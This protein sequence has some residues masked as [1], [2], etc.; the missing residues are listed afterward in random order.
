MVV[1]WV[2]GFEGGERVV[3]VEVEEL[4]V[5]V[6]E[7]R[8]LPWVVRGIFFCGPLPAVPSPLQ[9]KVGFHL[10]RGVWFIYLF[11]FFGDVFG[12]VAAGLGDVAVAD[13]TGAGVAGVC[14]AGV[15]GFGVIGGSDVGVAFAAT[16]AA[17][18]V[19]AFF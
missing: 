4:V 11:F 18:A 14:V 5:F 9:I 10:F 15:A 12:V 1:V 6:V 13:V 16:T 2:V 7:R 17:A 19:W 8:D 3:E